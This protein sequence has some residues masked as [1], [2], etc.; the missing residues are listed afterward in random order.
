M[1]RSKLLSFVTAVAIMLSAFSG[2]ALN[3]EA[4]TAEIAN[5]GIE[6]FDD[7]NGTDAAI[8]GSVSELVAIDADYT[9]IS[10]DF[11]AAA[12]AAG[13]I[14]TNSKGNN[15]VSALTMT[16][17]K[18]VFS[19]KGN[20]YALNKKS[21]TIGDRTVLNCLKTKGDTAFV[22]NLGKAANITVYTNDDT[23]K[24]RY[25]ALGT[26]AG[27]QDIP[28]ASQE[29]DGT[30]VITTFENVQPGTI[31]IGSFDDSAGADL[32]V[33]GFVVE[34]SD[35]PAPTPTQSTGGNVTPAPA[36]PTPVPTPA[37]LQETPAALQRRPLPGGLA[38]RL[39]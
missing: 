6:L 7:R 37:R 16:A 34:I 10:E 33:A 26:S 18:K 24:N 21:S 23:G 5:G 25:A 8:E 27:A 39:P 13:R 2:L 20:E 35:G 36:T 14:S 3:A 9:F 29:I 30:S 28:R 31:Y 22:I 32:Y 4:D 17:D 11:Y 1:R 38:P 12:T 15:V 19:N